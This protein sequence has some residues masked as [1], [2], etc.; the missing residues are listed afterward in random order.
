MTFVTRRP[1]PGDLRYDLVFQ[2][3]FEDGTSDQWSS[4]SP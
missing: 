1:E 2:D 4:A 3:G